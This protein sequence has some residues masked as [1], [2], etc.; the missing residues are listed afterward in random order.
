MKSITRG[1]YLSL[2]W[3]VVRPHKCPA[4]SDSDGR[5]TGLTDCCPQ[6]FLW[7]EVR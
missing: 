1:Q 3:C 2:C 5:Y 4:L 6:C 7:C